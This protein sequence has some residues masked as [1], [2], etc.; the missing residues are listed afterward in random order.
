M[1]YEAGTVLRHVHFP[2]TAVVSLV[3]PLQDGASTEV[4]VVGPKA[5]SASAPSWAEAR[6]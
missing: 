2:V 6:R 5:W 3:S 1:L 4:A